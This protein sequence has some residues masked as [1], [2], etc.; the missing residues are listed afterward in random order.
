MIRMEPQVQNKSR[1]ARRSQRPRSGT[2]RSGI[3]RSWIVVVLATLAALAAVPVPAQAAPQGDI[4]VFGDSYATNHADELGPLCGHSPTSWPARLA[5]RTNTR[6]VD[7]SCSGAS[8]FGRYNVYDQAPKA[9]AKGAFSR[10]TRAVLIQLGFNDWVDRLFYPRCFIAQCT[11]VQQ[12]RRL[13]A[14]AYANRLRALVDY[15]RF[16]APTATISLVGYPELFAEGTRELCTRVV[17]GTAITRPQTIAAIAAGQSLRTAQ[18]GAARILGIGFIDTHLVTAGHG[19]CADDP[20]VRGV[21]YPHVGAAEGLLVGHPTA[22]G[23]AALAAA[24]AG[25]LT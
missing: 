20:W 3:V 2:F 10:R 6:L 5:R 19:M 15:V 11:D 16:Y 8:L 9:V 14:T 1:T 23:D 17:G 21:L 13:N 4:V 22:K 25:T 24:I 18:A 7:V 12:F